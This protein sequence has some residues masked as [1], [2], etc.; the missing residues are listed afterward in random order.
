M[1]QSPIAYIVFNRP[2]HTEQTFAVL[3]E[4]RPS[5]LFIIADGPRPGHPTDNA[6]LDG[7]RQ[8]LAAGERDRISFLLLLRT[9][10]APRAT[11]AR[12]AIRVASR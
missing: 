3:R 7:A 1:T 12:D 4:Q 9:G 11:F 10:E 5:Q 6:A 8:L 2:Q